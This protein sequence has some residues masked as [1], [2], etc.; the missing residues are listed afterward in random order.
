MA[1]YVILADAYPA[2]S[3]GLKAKRDAS[4]ATLAMVENARAIAA[5]VAWGQ[6][7]AEA[8]W[9]WRLTDGNAPPPPPF[10]GVL[11]IAGMPAA[12]G[13]W[14]PTPPTNTPGAGVQFATMTPWVLTRPS[15]FRLPPAYALA[16]AEFATDLNETRTMG[17]FSGSPRSADQ[18][19][20]VLFWAS[21]TPLTWD[22][23]AAQLSA[24]RSLTVAQNAH[25]FALL[26]VTMADAVIA[27]WDSKYGLFS[28]DRSR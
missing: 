11:G 4:L 9:A 28:G 2:Q 27:C 7:V 8:I 26:N 21:N 23:V 24:Q 15:Q 20:L 22:R 14:R 12:V 25:L 5:G 18:S 10:E 19:E 3:A 16:S 6:T 17:A 13:V 1:A